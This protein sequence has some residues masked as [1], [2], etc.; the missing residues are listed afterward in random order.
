MQVA[1]AKRASSKGKL[2]MLTDKICNQRDIATSPPAGWSPERKREYFDWA[3]SVADQ[4]RGTNE[5]LE[6]IFDEAYGL[7]P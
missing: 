6:A 4:L 5:K 3:K 2:A 1:H 7:G